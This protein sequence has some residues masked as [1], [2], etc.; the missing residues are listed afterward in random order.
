MRD[1]TCRRRFA[2]STASQQSRAER[3]ARGG[4]GDQQPAPRIVDCVAA[5]ATGAQIEAE[6]DE[7]GE[8]LEDKVRMKPQAGDFEIERKAQTAGPQPPV[9]AR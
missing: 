3:R 8:Q 6:A 5:P 9:R 4:R 1:S 2:P 7:V